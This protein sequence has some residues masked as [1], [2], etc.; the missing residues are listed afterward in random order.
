MVGEGGGGKTT[1][2]ILFGS[3]KTRG[4]E[5]PDGCPSGEPGRVLI[6]AAEDG[7]ADTIIPRF[8]TAGAD[9]SDGRVKILTARVSIPKKGKNPA[10]VHPV[11]LQDLAYWRTVFR[12]RR[13]SILIIDP[14]PAYLGRGVNDNKNSDV[15]TALQSFAA[16][17]NEFGVCVSPSP[18]PA[19]APIAS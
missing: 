9:M 12:T 19:R 11:C 4:E 1:I 6:L 10:M 3:I 15:Q 14:V 17:A 5:F 7:A 16:L 8:I 13:P 18:I 2:A